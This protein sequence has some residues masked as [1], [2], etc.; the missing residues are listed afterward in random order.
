M[1]R[2]ARVLPLLLLAPLLLTACGEEVKGA[3]EAGA[4]APAPGL[5]PRARALGIAPELVYVTGAPGFALAPQSA[6]V[7]GGD[8][9]SATY[10]SRGSGGQLR[11]YVDRG[12]MSAADCTE[13][14][15]VCEE[16]EDGVWYRSGGGGH[17]YAVV[18]EGHVVRLE[19][20]ASVPRDVVRRAAED[21]H[22][23]SGEEAAGLLPSAPAGD[24]A[25][26]GPA[27]DAKPTGPVERGD[28][29]PAGDG[30]PRNDVGAGG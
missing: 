14:Q 8:G 5:A 22:R 7:Y 29:P 3:G 6:G 2:T 1:I 26:T 10:V 15:T 12:T 23:P 25:P 9:F 16:E 11:L 21:A 30:A 28:L 20:D 13:R 24:A 18:K 19:G 17:E 4:A 27:D